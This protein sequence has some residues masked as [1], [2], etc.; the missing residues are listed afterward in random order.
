MSTAAAA[1]T[2]SWMVSSSSPAAARG[3]EFQSPIATAATP[4]SCFGLTLSLGVFVQIPGLLAS[5]SLAGT[6]TLGVEL[7]KRYAPGNDAQQ[8]TTSQH[9]SIVT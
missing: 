2:S 4:P 1:A 9:L 5:V 6:E 7:T 8:E 3:A